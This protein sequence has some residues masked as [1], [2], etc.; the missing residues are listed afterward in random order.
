MRWASLAALLLLVGCEKQ[1]VKAVEF[2]RTLFF[3]PRLSDSSFN[4]FSCATCHSTTPDS[5]ASRLFSGYSLHNVASRPSWWGGYEL[6]LLDAVNVCFVYFMRGDPALTA[7]DPK[8][9]SLYEFLRSISPDAVAPALPLTIVKNVLAVPDG[10]RARGEQVY[11]SACQQC[12]GDAQSGSGKLTE[13]A[14]TLSDEL[15]SY[16]SR[17]PNVSPRLVVTEKVRH[18]QF[19]GIGGNMPPYSQEALS[20]EDLGALLTFLAP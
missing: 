1:P 8:S 4:S 5:D 17:F 11:R 14:P 20:D 2:G 16:P 3:E 19:F 18:G 7:D 6:D 12:H 15:A 10:D 9:K 13:L